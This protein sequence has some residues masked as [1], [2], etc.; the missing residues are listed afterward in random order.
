VAAGG[1]PVRAPGP[2]RGMI[3][4]QPNLFPWLSVLD[5]VTL[6][7]GWANTANKRSTRGRWTGWGAWA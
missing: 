2:D 3:F 1:K 7:R 6:A 5:N 4:Q